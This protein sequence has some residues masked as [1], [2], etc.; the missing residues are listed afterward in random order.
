MFCY[1]I[2]VSLVV[3]ELVYV[4]FLLD[5]VNLNTCCRL[6][7]KALFDISK[8]VLFI[9]VLIYLCALFSKFR[10]GPQASRLLS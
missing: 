4:T 2:P 5:T 6:V 1:S 10:F 9:H 7:Q 3:L 8:K